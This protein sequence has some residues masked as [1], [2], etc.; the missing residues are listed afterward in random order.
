MV[1]KYI[2]KAHYFI[3]RLEF[4][5]SLFIH[6]FGFKKKQNF[7]KSMKNLLT[8]TS[9]AFSTQAANTRHNTSAQYVKEQRF[10][11]TNLSIRKILFMHDEN[12][13]LQF[14]N[15]FLMTYIHFISVIY[16]L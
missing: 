12:V 5:F 16:C 4:Y 10:I 1:G 3:N 13:C 7:Q 14:L 9:L 6:S 8:S 11:V 15:I 2:E